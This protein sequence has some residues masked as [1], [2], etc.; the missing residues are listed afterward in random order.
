MANLVYIRQ[1]QKESVLKL[2]EFRNSTSGKK[3]NKQKYNR[4]CKDGIQALYSPKV[5]GLKTGLYKRYDDNKTLQEW[6]E[7]KWGLDKGT[8]TNRPVGKGSKPRQEDMTYFQTKRW[9]FNEGTTVLDLDNL[10]DFCFYHVCLESKYVANSE[11][12]WKEHKWPKAKYYVAHQNESEEL[13]YKRNFKKSKANGA[14]ASDDL[15]LSWKRKFCVIFGLVNARVELTEEQAHNLLFEL[16]DQDK[17]VLGVSQVDRFLDYYEMMK[18]ETTK[19]KLEADYLLKTLVDYNIVLEKL[20]TYTWA[21]KGK[22]IG[23]SESEAVEFL[24]N[25]K[26][27]GQRDELEKELKLKKG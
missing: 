16:I 7:E 5:G 18:N 20:G 21:S 27:Q 4:F 10:D 2:S 15:T 14:L 17:F 9:K 26:K 1:I 12:E 23:Y 19:E 8:L 3:M 11:K 6:A 13:K 22:E 25:P 24:V